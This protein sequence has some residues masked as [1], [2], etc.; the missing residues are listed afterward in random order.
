MVKPI[1]EVLTCP[2]AARLFNVTED[3]LKSLCRKGTFTQDEARKAGIYWLVTRA[4]L[5]RVFGKIE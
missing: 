1:N 3:K 2:E 5:E 4:G